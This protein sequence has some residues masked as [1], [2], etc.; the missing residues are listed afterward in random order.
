MQKELIS[1]VITTYKREKKYIEEAI[2]SV[3][4]QTY[5]NIEV[6]VIDDNG[7]NQEYSKKVQELCSSKNVIYIKNKRNRGAQF[8]RNI[9]ILNSKG[10]YI[11][12]LDDDDIW[13]P[14][15]LEKQI[16]YFSDVDVGMVFCDGYSFENGNISNTSVF[17]EASIFGKPIS[18]ELELFNDYIGSTSQAL[19]KKECFS[20]VGLFDTDMPARQ[21]YEMWLRISRSYKIVGAPEKLL[22]YR[23]HSG[24]RISTNLDKCYNS[25]KL[26]L[27]KHK[28]EYNRNRYAK[29]KIILRIFDTSIRAKW[30]GRA[31]YYFSY[32]F[33]VSPQCVIDVITRRIKEIPFDKFYTEEMLFKRIKIKDRI[34]S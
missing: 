22:Y 30:V 15:K 23:V 29:S 8:S 28:S 27:E 13:L 25:Y 32:A 17:R 24:E 18:H 33:F 5:K 10:E 7:K 19:I 1:V 21:D 12:F 20:K 2:D 9:G 31:L 4:N 26:V 3:L 6:L 34:N 14:E 11:A 16:N